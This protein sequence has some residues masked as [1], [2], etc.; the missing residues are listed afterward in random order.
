MFLTWKMFSLI[1]SCF[2]V[3]SVE[4]HLIILFLHCK[5]AVSWPDLF[6]NSYRLW[7]FLENLF[8]NL[9][10]RSF[11]LCWKRFL[12]TCK[13]YNYNIHSNYTF[14]LC[15][16][17]SLQFCKEAISLPDFF[18]NSYIDYVMLISACMWKRLRS[19]PL[20]PRGKIK[21]NGW[22]QSICVIVTNSN[23]TA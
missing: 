12:T 21:Y 23:K 1:R 16:H 11:S 3:L 9:F 18:S 13:F 7:C 10:F 15:W 14:A 8:F 17:I 19:N 20:R 22:K 5:E 6:S 4:I 2:L